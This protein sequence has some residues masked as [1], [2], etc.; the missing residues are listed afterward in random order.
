MR[1]GLLTMAVM[2]ISLGAT[3]AEID[4][5]KST[6]NWKGSKVTGK[7]HVGEIKMKSASV[8]MVDSNIESG[9]ITFDMNSIS[10]TDIQGKWADKFISHL[11]SDDFFDVSKFPTAHLTINKISRGM[12]NGNLTIKGKTEAISFPVKRMGNKYV[13]KT[14]FDRTKFGIIY[15]SGNFFKNLG[16]KLINDDVEIKFSIALKGAKLAQA[17]P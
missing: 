11:K 7:N 9:K 16:D 17:N 13:G 14:T 15:G 2:L 10:V 3:A 4:T 5:A 6:I 8:K 12:L 1:Y